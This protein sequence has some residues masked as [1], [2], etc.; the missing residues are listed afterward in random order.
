MELQ[1]SNQAKSAVC[2]GK[3]AGVAASRV[4]RACVL[5]IAMLAASSVHTNHTDCLFEFDRMQPSSSSFSNESSRSIR[6]ARAVSISSSASFNLANCE[7]DRDPA[8]G[9]YA[10]LHR[11]KLFHAYTRLRMRS[12]NG[13]RHKGGKSD[14]EGA[15]PNK[16]ET[17]E[18]EEEEESQT[19]T[20]MM[21]KGRRGREA[22]KR[23]KGRESMKKRRIAG[24]RQTN[25]RKKKTR[26]IR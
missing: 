22:D 10:W 20:H 12:L 13:A 25:G 11:L 1:K 15:K 26:K 8:A 23:K 9:A 19:Q 14:V 24:T 2:W 7:L 17:K 4:L 18:E 6:D 16:N 5:H 21:K 3:R